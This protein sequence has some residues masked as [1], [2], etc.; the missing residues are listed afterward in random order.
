MIITIV[1]LFTSMVISAVGAS[2]AKK[3]SKQCQEGCHKNSMWS[4]IISGIAVGVI[5]IVLI[6]YI[7]TSRKDI[8]SAA[9]QKLG[10]YL[11]KGV[12]TE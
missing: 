6:I 9:H 5:V 11:K 7:Y 4:A 3:G 12:K 2:D 10:G 1:L 8:A